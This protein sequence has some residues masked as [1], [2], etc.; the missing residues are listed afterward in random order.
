MDGKAFQ[1]EI[2]SQKVGN[3]GIPILTM[4]QLNVVEQNRLRSILQQVI[5]KP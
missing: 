2:E 5:I 4:N 1:Q 3:L